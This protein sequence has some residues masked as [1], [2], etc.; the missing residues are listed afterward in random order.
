[1]SLAFATARLNI[2]DET[3]RHDDTADADFDRPIRKVDNKPVVDVAIQSFKLDL[4]ASADP[5]D[6][7]QVTTSIQSV[8]G[9]SVTVLFRTEYSGGAYSGEVKAL[10]IADLIDP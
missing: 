9:N 7:V 1:M 2:T 4:V 5:T 6:I 3:G 10:A 8:S